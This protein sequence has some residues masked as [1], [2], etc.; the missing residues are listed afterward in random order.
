MAKGPYSEMRSTS[1]SADMISPEKVEKKDPRARSLTGFDKLCELHVKGMSMYE[2]ESPVIKVAWLGLVSLGDNTTC[3]PY[4]DV[5]HDGRG[6]VG[7]ARVELIKIVRDE[8]SPCFEGFES[9]LQVYGLSVNDVNMRL[10]ATVHRICAVLGHAYR[11]KLKLAH[12][13]KQS[14]VG[15]KENLMKTH[16]VTGTPPQK[17]TE[18][19]NPGR[20][21]GR[22]HP[23]KELRP[24]TRI[25]Q[26]RL[27]H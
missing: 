11:L 21:A 27:E 23:I 5:V 6:K 3:K 4:G 2:R 24:I 10:H 8:K 19:E 17:D 9:S 22:L 7:Q 26:E 13:N 16:P 12:K 15:I 1:R 20:S 14:A 25:P 18:E